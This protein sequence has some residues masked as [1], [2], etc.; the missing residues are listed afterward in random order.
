LDC[1]TFRGTRGTAE[2]LRCSM[3]NKRPTSRLAK[4]GSQK[5]ALH[6]T[7]GDILKSSGVEEAQ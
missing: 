6:T 1:S 7:P 2:Q 3:T 4:T 5:P